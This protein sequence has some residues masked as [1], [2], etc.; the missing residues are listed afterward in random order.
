VYLHVIHSLLT[1][2][3]QDTATDLHIEAPVVAAAKAHEKTGA[4]VLL[5]WALQHQL[6]IIPKVRTVLLQFFFRE[7]KYT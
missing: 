3:H 5:R 7:N 2:T 6:V 1:P 4:Q